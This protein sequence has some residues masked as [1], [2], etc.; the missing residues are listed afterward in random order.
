MP[1]TREDAIKL[2]QRI[3]SGDETVCGPNQTKVTKV[4]QE[5]VTTQLTEDQ[6]VDWAAKDFR[7]DAIPSI[8]L[9]AEMMQA[10]LGNLVPSES[11]VAGW[12]LPWTPTNPSYPRPP[13]PRYP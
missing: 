6:F 1:M 4:L 10:L 3:R 13:R 7:P 8:K 5:I 12:Y 11:T 2:F 9:P